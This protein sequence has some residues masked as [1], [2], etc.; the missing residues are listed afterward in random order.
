MQERKTLLSV[1]TSSSEYLEKNGVDMPRLSAEIII[2]KIL[3]MKRLNLYLEYNRPLMESELSNIRNA[4]IQRGKNRTPIEYIFNTSEFYGREFYVDERVLIPRIE[5]EL[6]VEEA[7]KQIEAIKNPKILDI[8][9]G[10]GA[11]CLTLA[12]ERSDAAIVGVDISKDALEV[13]KRNREK[14]EVVNCNLKLSNLFESL[15]EE[16]FD[17]IISNPPYIS[18]LEYETLP[19]ETLKEPKVALVAENLGLDIYEKIL[20]K[21]KEHLTPSG[22]IVFEIGYN[23]EMGILELLKRYNFNTSC[24]IKDYFKNPRIAIGQY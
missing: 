18:Y 24:V 2:S 6:V 17:L 5:T 12:L 9:V 22:V 1:L 20:Q 19:I 14:L 8:G 10:S 15:N 4:M 16:K 23:Q 11:I 21:A 13:A 7:L 3:K